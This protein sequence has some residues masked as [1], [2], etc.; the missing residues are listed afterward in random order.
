MKTLRLLTIL[1]PMALTAQ[2]G[3]NTTTPGA[4]LD[5]RSSNQAAPTPT[6]GLLIPKI[7]SFPAINPTSAQNGMM[8]YL[9]TTIGSN[10]PGFYYW[11]DSLL[12]WL[13]ISGKNGWST[14]GNSGT[15]DGVNFI[16]TTDN[17]PLNFKVN[18]D[19]AG[20]IDFTLENTFFGY[21]TGKNTT[22]NLNTA[23]GNRALTDNSTGIGN[24]ALGR[25]ALNANTTASYST[26]L[27]LEAMEYNTT[28]AYNTA[29]G[30]RS[31]RNN[32]SGVESTALGVGALEFGT[33]SNRNV[34]VGRGAM[35]TYGT[36]GQN[37]AIGNYALANQIFTNGG[38]AYY[39]NNTAVGY[40]SM[41]NNNPT[42]TN[43][44]NQ[45]VAL[46]TQSLFSNTTGSGNS[47][48][49]FLSLFNNVTG[50]GNA[51]L[52]SYAMTD[53]AT[54]N[55]NVGVGLE[56]LQFGVTG[57][58]NIAVGW[59]AMR[60]NL[61]GGE[62]TA[63]GVGAL[64][65]GTISNRNVAIGRGAMINS[66]TAANNVA[67]GNYALAN[68]TFTNGGAS[69]NANNTAIGYQAM[70]NNNPTAT[71][72]GV[73][74]LAVGAQSLFN[75]TIGARNT[76]IG[77]QSLFSNT[78]GTN[79]CA[80]GSFALQDNT[81]GNNNIAIGYTA[82]QNNTTAGHNIAIGLN[83]LST[84]SFNNGNTAWVSSNT[85]IGYNALFANQPTTTN[86]GILNSAVG[87]YALN[88]NTTGR[89][90][91]ALGVSALFNNTSADRNVGV[92]NY[93]GY[94]STG[95]QN[96]FMGFWAGM[97]SFGATNGANNTAIGYQSLNKF[98]SGAKNTALGENAMLNL[99]SGDSNVG[100]GSFS[101]A[102]QTSGSYNTSIGASAGYG[103][104]VFTG[105]YNFYGGHASGTVN[106]SGSNNAFV[107]AFAD[108]GSNNLVYATAIGANALV[109]CSNCLSLGGNTASTRTNVGINTATPGFGLEINEKNDGSVYGVGLGLRYTSRT[110]EISH[111]NTNDLWFSYNGLL[112]AYISSVGG[113][114]NVSDRR[115]KTDI[116]PMESVLDKVRQLR[117]SHYRF[118]KNNPEQKTS[119]GFIAQEVL[120]LFPE[121]VSHRNIADPKS[122]L[123]DIYAVDYANMVVIA[124][125][126]I[127]EQQAEIDEL[128]Q[129][130]A[131]EKRQKDLLQARLDS[132]EQRLQQLEAQRQD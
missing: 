63:V 4:Q 125:K 17:K 109:N 35:F 104:S 34:A 123:R 131:D 40:Q 127:Q 82:A 88:S 28:G 7:D 73:Q 132:F 65:N 54:G 2:V 20:R 128:R 33:I 81:L 92:G 120:P 53:N 48:I 14:A 11:D 103:A 70:F 3:I 77:F 114:Y 97:G 22:A 64:E 62:S 1:I 79:N 46:G 59:R 6:D 90:N 124:L 47:A 60:N 21:Q 119:M 111:A 10:A 112:S 115:L 74:N 56:A 50:A 75:N 106:Q 83:A 5:I 57:S 69:F 9:T 18:N 27:G 98:T 42:A 58:Y 37:V 86:N 85:A 118:I 32:L 80:L 44:G 94:H 110:W 13:P 16:G 8:V 117:P 71:T 129:A 116:A 24:T 29:V 121:V 99:T 68:Q 89:D 113:T 105:S 102:N 12:V 41:Y 31:L 87:H 67:L 51:A 55:Y 72:N 61:T 36:A 19:A 101:L 91:T 95:A 76:G 52:G 93:A 66:G 49:G 15:S 38:S 25:L 130:I 78:A 96:T 107:G 126:A 84:Q 108:T 122:E 39:S 30:W 23:M 26:A 100:L 45:N 43:N